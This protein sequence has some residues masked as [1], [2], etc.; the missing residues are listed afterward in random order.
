MSRDHETRSSRSARSLSVRIPSTNTPDNTHEVS[1]RQ[2]IDNVK[3]IPPKVNSSIPDIHALQLPKIEEAVLAARK[4]ENAWL[5]MRDRQLF[6]LLKHAVCAAEASLS[7]EILRKVCPKEAELLKDKTMT[8]KVRLRS[9]AVETKSSQE[10]SKQSFFNNISVEESKQSFF[11]NISVEESKR[12]FFNN[13]SVEESKQS[14]FNNISVEESKEWFFNNIS[15]KESKQSFFNNISVEESKEWFFNNMSVEE[16]KRS[17]FNNISVEESKQSFFNNI[18]VEESK[19]SFFNNISVEESKQSFFHNIS[20]EESKEWFFNN[21]SVKESKQSFFNNISVEESKEWFFNNISVEESKQSFFNNISVEESKQSF[22]NN[23]SIEESNQ[24]FFNNISVEESKQS[25][26]NNI[27]ES[28]EWFFNKKSV[29]ESK[30]SFF[31]NISVEESKQS[32]FNNISIEESKQSFFNNISVEESKEWFFNNMSVEESKQSFFNNI[33]VKESKQ[34]KSIFKC[35]K[36]G[37]GEF[38]PH[39][40]FKIF[41]ATEQGMTVHY[42]SGKK[43]IEPASEAA[44]DACQ[45]MGHRRFYDQLISDQLQ[46]DTHAVT[47]EVDIITLKDYMQYLSLLDETP[48][49]LGGRDNCWRKLTL[50]V[51]PR[52]T[53]F[54]DIVQYLYTHKMSPQLLDELPA[55]LALPLNEDVQLNQI[56]IISQLRP[57]SSTPYKQYTRP[58]S[59]PSGKK[60]SRWSRKAARMR[61]MKMKRLYETETMSTSM[62]LSTNRITLTEQNPV[63]PLVGERGVKKMELNPEDSVGEEEEEWETEAHKL[64][65]WTQEL[66]LDELVAT[67][68]LSAMSLATSH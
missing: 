8:S 54:Y 4:I 39:I 27:S 28:K 31:N 30:R 49:Y 10:E 59:P 3:P 32:F 51:L 23:I 44:R 22:F 19:Q 6:K 20:V 68:R 43:M 53:I 7:F 15:V 57:V 45:L 40:F 17:F 46:R 24:S 26:F 34:S 60:S 63:L 18:S 14:F 62:E 37:G 64:Y 16:S 21:I 11:N 42:V 25:F 56:R 1:P 48:A 38:P 12:S 52:Q 65:E 58:L 9:V 29:E 61:A 2:Y 35:L 55:L 41:L 67:P 47:D 50:E 36:F 5:G 33:S 66:S 13:I